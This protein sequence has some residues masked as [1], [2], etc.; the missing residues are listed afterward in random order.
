MS[1][2][3]SLI[4]FGFAYSCFASYLA[5]RESGEKWM[6]YY[7]TWIDKKCGVSSGVRWHGKI[8]FAVLFAGTGWFLASQ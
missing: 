6:L 5:Y 7:P 2:G 1:P 3:I 8:A 4:V